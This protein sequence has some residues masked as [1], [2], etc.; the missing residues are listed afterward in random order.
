MLTIFSQLFFS[1]CCFYPFCLFQPALTKARSLECQPL[2]S[3]HVAIKVKGMAFEHWVCIVSSLCCFYPF[4]L[5][6]PALTRARSLECQPLIS[7]HV[8]IN[9]KND[10][11]RTISV[12]GFLL[13]AAILSQLFFSLCCFY[14]FCLF[15]PALTKA[16]SLECQPLISQHV[17]IKVKGMA[18]EHWV[19]IVSPLCCHSFAVVFFSVL[20]LPLL[21]IPASPYKS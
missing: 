1:L 17:A 15:Q 13:C 9:V 19:C 16:R 5:F 6:Q 2:I 20:F 3:Q 11:C 10:G 4:C 12:H 21:P 8:A 18:F 14:P 7:Q